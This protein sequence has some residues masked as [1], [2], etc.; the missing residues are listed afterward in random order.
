MATFTEI[1]RTSQV[2]CAQNIKNGAF[3]DGRAG[4]LRLTQDGKAVESG[5][6]GK[7]YPLN[8]YYGYGIRNGYGLDFDPV[9]G[10]LWDTEN[11]PDFR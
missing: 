2:Q 11:G 1:K 6:L 5:I 3:P 10:K 7:K 9:S 4:I 8:L